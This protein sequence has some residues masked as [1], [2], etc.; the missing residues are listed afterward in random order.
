VQEELEAQKER[1]NKRLN[2]EIQ[3]KMAFVE[4]FRA[5]SSKARQAASR[6]KMA[7][8][9][10]KEL[11]N[12]QP[13]LRRKELHFQW[14]EPARAEKL[15]LSAADMEYRFP[16]GGGKW[17]PLSFVLYRGQRIALVGRNGCDKSV[18]LQVIAG[19]REKAGGSLRMGSLVRLG[20]F[21]QHQ[22]ETLRPQGTVLSE[23]RRLSDPR[24]S[25]E[26][27]MSVLGL[28]LLGQDFFERRVDTLSGG[29]KSRLILACW[30]S[31][32]TIWI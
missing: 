31:R 9:L 17:P 25:E 1:E 16:D 15:I 28:F 27:L 10:E 4:R 6:Q 18:L 32:P 24:T 30:T 3:R 12:L 26:E 8:K 5:K 11:E 21:S 13:E 29:E 14:P 22:M 7:K 20:Y 19:L 2:E 23:I